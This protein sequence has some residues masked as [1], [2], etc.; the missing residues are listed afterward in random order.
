MLQG[1]SPVISPVTHYK[2]CFY[3]G[4]SGIL[5]HLGVFSSQPAR[6]LKSSK[7]ATPNF[8]YNAASSSASV[9]LE[10]SRWPTSSRRIGASTHHIHSSPTSQGPPE[11]SPLTGRRLALSAPRSHSSRQEPTE[12]PKTQPLARHA[13]AHVRRAP[14][15]ARSVARLGLPHSS[16]ALRSLCAHPPVLARLSM[17][18]PP[19]PPPSALDGGGLGWPLDHRPLDRHG[20]T[21]RRSTVRNL[22]AAH[23]PCTHA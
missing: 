17:S 20:S 23:V 3:Y 22:L 5:R 19:Y 1:R 9:H 16:P 10:A 8:E 18:R 6:P 15:L 11:P 7:G 2:D 4:I 13:A 14:I 21:M 12:S